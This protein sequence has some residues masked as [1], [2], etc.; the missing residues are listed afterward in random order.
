M[1]ASGTSN[2]APCCESKL[3]LV[4]RVG[5]LSCRSQSVGAVHSP[6]PSKGLAST[7]TLS[8]DTP[9]LTRGG[10]NGAERKCVVA[11]LFALW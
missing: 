1:N 3:N 9:A 7:P 10:T 6:Q 11:F 2:G 4:P 5:Q 8:P